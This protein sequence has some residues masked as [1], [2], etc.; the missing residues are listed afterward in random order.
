MNHERHWY[1][2]EN[3]DEVTSPALLLYPERIEENIRR[4][5]AIAGR[6]ERLRPHIKTHKLPQ[7]IELQLRLGITRFKCATIAEAEMAANTGAQDILLAYQL[8]GPNFG[9]WAR[10]LERF[11]EATF[12][13][14]ADDENVLRQLS[15]TAIDAGQTY[16]VLLDIDVGQHRCGVEPSDRAIELYRFLTD[17]RG[18]TA[19]GLHAYDGHIYDSDVTQR[20]RACEAA[21]G[22]VHELLMRLRKA[23]FDVPRVVAGG[24]P[25]FPFHA[26]NPEFECSPGT[27]VLWDHG[28]ATKLRDMDFFPAALVLTRVISKPGGNRLCMDLGHKAL[29]SEM[30]HPRVQF[31]N[32]PEARFI[33]HSEE[34]LVV[35]TDDATKWRIGDCLYGVPWHVCPTMALHSF[36]T[37]IREHRA[38]KPWRITAREREISV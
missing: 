23:G 16:E 24:T 2:V 37:P 27:C 21:F 17:L 7:L 29:A 12:L 33:G 6:P 38:N 1:E 26:R 11:P 30:P 22:P 4:I 34:H 20:Q 10:L 5:I 36:A 14:I 25:T 35:E 3:I 9:R 15:E 18:L 13:T 8:V 31:L 28:Y 32:L 19:G